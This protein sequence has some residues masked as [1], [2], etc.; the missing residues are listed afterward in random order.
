MYSP[1][2]RL[3]TPEQI[4][5]PHNFH[6]KLPYSTYESGEEIMVLVVIHLQLQ[7]LEDR[8]IEY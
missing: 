7:N 3:F 8:R 1:P 4:K 6:P 2:L 5:Q